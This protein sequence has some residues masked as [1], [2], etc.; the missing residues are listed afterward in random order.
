MLS[1]PEWR[2]GGNVEVVPAKVG[3]DVEEPESWDI[4]LG[5]CW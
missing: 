1:S 3:E 5:T 2:G 4:L